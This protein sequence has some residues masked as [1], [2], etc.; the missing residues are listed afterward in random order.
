MVY[1]WKSE[2]KLILSFHRL[3]PRDQ[4]QVIRLGSKYLYPLGH[5]ADQGV[6]VLSLLPLLDET[7]LTR[8]L[9]KAEH[10]YEALEPGQGRSLVVYGAQL[11][12]QLLFW[13]VGRIEGRKIRQCQVTGG[14]KASGYQDQCSFLQKFLGLSITGQR[15]LQKFLN[16]P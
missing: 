1:V 3:G 15:N 9:R 4:T 8:P 6:A 14:R 7:W 11:Q 5:L 16:P 2:N 12:F 10:R 13:G